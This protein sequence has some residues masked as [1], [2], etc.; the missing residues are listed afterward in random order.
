MMIIALTLLLKTYSNHSVMSPKV[1]VIN[2]IKFIGLLMYYRK[3]KL[4]LLDIMLLYT[5]VQAAAEV[6][7]S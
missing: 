1:K 4:G 3:M 6:K 2:G 5:Y 7:V